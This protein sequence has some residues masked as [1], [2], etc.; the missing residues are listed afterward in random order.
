MDGNLIG[1]SNQN[2]ILYT[3]LYEVEFPGGEMTGLAAI[4]IAESMYAQC[5]VD[6]NEYLMLD[7]FIDYRKNGSALSVEDQ[8]IVV[9]GQETLRKST[10]SW[11]LCCKWKDR[12][13]LWEKLSDLKELHQIQVAKYAIVQGI[14]HECIQLVGSPS[15]EEKG[16][17][18]IHREMV[19]YLISE[20]N[21]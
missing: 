21:P 17:N 9:K 4:I 2:P 16:P 13:T 10:A 3:C 18:Y 5:D 12:S 6:R 8:K 15:P 20:K 7:A 14:Q 11:D 1:R 19:Q